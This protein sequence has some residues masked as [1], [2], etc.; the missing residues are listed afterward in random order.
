MSEPDLLKELHLD[1]EADAGDGRRW[2]WRLLLALVAGGLAV[3][4]Y[5]GLA[6]QALT[7]ATAVAEAP[8][9]GPVTVLDATGYV[10]EIEIGRASCRERV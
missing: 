10:I 6:G 7:V 4:A 9:A 5:F 8:G 3:G 1:R 2:P